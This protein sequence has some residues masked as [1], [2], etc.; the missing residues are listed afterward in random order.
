MSDLTGKPPPDSIDYVE[1]SRNALRGVVRSVLERTEKEGLPGEHYY[2]ISFFT[3]RPGVEI[4]DWLRARHPEEM[5]I[6]LQH[7]FHGLKV[8]GNGFRVVLSFNQVESKIAV[9]FA[10]VT[11]FTDPSA[12][13]A[14]RFMPV[15]KEEAAPAD[16][17][18]LPASADPSDANVATEVISLDAFRS[19]RSSSA[20]TPKGAA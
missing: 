12:S 1:L 18:E 17:P 9:P 5:T 3:D 14:L 16:E 6:V 19:K 8:D 2:F 15:P 11:G 20:P 13:F 7:S 10:A 4:P